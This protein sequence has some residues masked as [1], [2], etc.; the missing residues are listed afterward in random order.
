M[1]LSAGH[2]GTSPVGDEHS[3]PVLPVALVFLNAEG[4]ALAE[5]RVAELE[6]LLSEDEG[7]LDSI[8]NLAEREWRSSYGM[9]HSPRC[10]VSVAEGARGCDCHVGA[11]LAL[12]DRRQI[13]K[14]A[15][16]GSQQ[17]G[18]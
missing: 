9:E 12:R 10:P 16:A 15:L 7:E 4:R 14:A 11:L 1:S 6:K 13:R 3:R 8:L 5:A 17:E 2:P 18:E